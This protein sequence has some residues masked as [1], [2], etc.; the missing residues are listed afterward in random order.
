MCLFLVYCSA[1]AKR[2]VTLTGQATVI[3]VA[4]RDAGDNPSDEDCVIYRYGSF[5]TSIEVVGKLLLIISRCIKGHKFDL[6]L[7]VL[8]PFLCDSFQRA[9]KKWR[10]YKCTMLWWQHPKL[11]KM[12]WISPLPAREGECLS[13]VLLQ[14]MQHHNITKTK[15]K[16]FTLITLYL[17]YILCSFPKEVCSVILDAECLR[18]I[19]TMCNMVEPSRECQ[20]VLR[21]FFNDSGVYCI[22]VSM[23]DDVSLAVTST[24]I[25]VRMGTQHKPV[26][27]FTYS[28]LQHSPTLS[29]LFSV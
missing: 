23:A 8:C 10:S 25:T 29:C 5:C 18:P 12:H 4:K 9:L 28:V 26:Q 7:Y 19:H 21:H 3:V 20:L 13:T 17:L 16:L 24:K 15:K 14:I 11:T 27:N 1:G 22:N 2:A 6:W